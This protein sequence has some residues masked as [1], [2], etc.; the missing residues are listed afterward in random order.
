MITVNTV[1]TRTTTRT[2]HQLQCPSMF[3]VSTDND[4]G[5]N[6]GREQN[7]WQ[8]TIMCGPYEVFTTGYQHPTPSEAMG[9]AYLLLA[10]ALRAVLAHQQP[11]ELF[12]DHPE[13][14]E[15]H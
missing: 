13:I 1:S 10:Q 8:A 11:T 7:L 4:N 9:A 6:L 12:D 3:S 5:I 2:L 15:E 14:L